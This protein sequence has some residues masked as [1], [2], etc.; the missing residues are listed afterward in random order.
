MID[1]I[2]IAMTI[3]LVTIPF[4]IIFKS[5]NYYK[6]NIII[7]IIRKILV[8]MIAIILYMGVSKYLYI[9]SLLDS[10]EL[11]FLSQ[12]YESAFTIICMLSLIGFITIPFI[13]ESI[14]FRFIKLFTWAIQRELCEYQKHDHH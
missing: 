14:I 8:L 5:S 12:N 1:F 9:D 4:E 6:K 3:L 7:T 11:L 10:N 13:T 2:K